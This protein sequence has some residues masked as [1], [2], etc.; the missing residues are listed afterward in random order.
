MANFR[1]VDFQSAFP[2]GHNAAATFDRK[3]NYAR[4]AAMGREMLLHGGE[5]FL[6]PV[7]A[8]LGTFPE[9]GRN[10]EGFGPDPYLS[11]ELV[12]PTIEGIQDQG[13]V[14]TAKHYLAYEQEHFR[15]VSEAALNGFDIAESLSS[16]VN[17]RAMHELYLW[18][19]QKRP[20]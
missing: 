1:V 7:V 14:A 4:G 19:V 5:V 12:A 9:G 11:G 16:N 8:P 13:I 6:R 17:D 10:W 2:G 20:K 3:L 18:Y 15:L